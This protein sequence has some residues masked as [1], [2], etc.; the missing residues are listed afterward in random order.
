MLPPPPPPP[1]PPPLY[2]RSHTF[3]RTGSQAKALERKRVKD[4]VEIYQSIKGTRASG[5]PRSRSAKLR[6]NGE[7]DGDGGRVGR[8]RSRSASSAGS[9]KPREND[10]SDGD[11]GGDDADDDADDSEDCD[12]DDVRWFSSRSAGIQLCVCV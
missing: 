1:P 8:P 7:S 12:G 6:E 11:G 3:T 4:Q 10:D 5:R 9:V 2:T